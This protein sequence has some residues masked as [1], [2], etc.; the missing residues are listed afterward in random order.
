M[1]STHAISCV[2][3]T[4]GGPRCDT[5]TPAPPTTR[6]HKHDRARW[7]EKRRDRAGA[8][9]HG[10]T[11]AAAGRHVHLLDLPNEILEMV[12]R[13]T[14]Q[15][16]TITMTRAVTSLRG[17]C[18]RL[19]ALCQVPFLTASDVGP[20]LA[21]FVAF[22]GGEYDPNVALAGA[23]VGIRLVSATDLQRASRLRWQFMRTCARYAI[24]SL[25]AAKPDLVAPQLDLVPFSSFAKT[26]SQTHS[27]A[28][29]LKP[30]HGAFT[31][32]HISLTQYDDGR[33]KVRVECK[34]GANVWCPEPAVLDKPMQDVINGALIAA[35]MHAID[36][37]G[38]SPHMRAL[39]AESID[40]F[41]TC[42]NLSA[43]FRSTRPGFSCSAG[44]KRR[45]TRS[46]S[47]DVSPIFCV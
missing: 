34:I 18:G 47:L 7:H 6:A 21:P 15:Q 19:E 13:W 35:A 2:Q 40:L 22:D 17:C 41:V 36:T 44:Y 32:D 12:V 16:D 5:P 4:T 30:M 14:L 11:D 27:I 23:T 26:E 46:A 20:H 45:E 25:L 31:Y 37:T 10:D 28:L 9:L 39:V 43:R 33:T 38:G 1:G 8:G 42:P 3:D 24:Y 29:A